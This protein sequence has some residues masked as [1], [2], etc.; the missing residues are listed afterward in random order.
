MARLSFRLD[1][2]PLSPYFAIF[3]SLSVNCLVFDDVI[4]SSPNIFTSSALLA[5]PPIFIMSSSAFTRY[6][7][8]GPKIDP[9][10]A[11]RIQ[12][13]KSAGG[14]PMCF[15]IYK[16]ISVPVRPRPAL[17]CIAIAPLVASASYMN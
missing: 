9:G 13:M 17:Q 11:I 12:P 16:A 8:Y 4:L 2:C 10:L 6:Y 14:N 7:Y 1:P 3:C 15:I 5:A